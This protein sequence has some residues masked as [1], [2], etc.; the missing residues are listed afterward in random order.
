MG[1]CLAHVP[2]MG[3]VLDSLEVEDVSSRFGS[4]LSLRALPSDP[5]RQPESGSERSKTNSSSQGFC[6]FVY[7]QA[8]VTYYLPF[9]EINIVYFSL[10]VKGN[11]NH[12]CFLLFFFPGNLSKWRF[13]SAQIPPDCFF[14]AQHGAGSWCKTVR[15]P[16]L[17]P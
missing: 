11:Q 16:S 17:F 4:H 13:S 14:G 9:A 10:L 3:P 12:C 15:V 5:T 1:L 8:Q 2:N 6:G 7:F